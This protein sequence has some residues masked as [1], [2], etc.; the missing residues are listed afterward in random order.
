MQPVYVD[1][2]A[3][4]ITRVL[5]VTEPRAVYELGGSKTYTY[6]ALLMTIAR[7]T[8][9]NPIF[10]PVP[11]GMW[12]CLAYVAE[13][14]PR[15]PITRNQVELMQIDNVVTPGFPGF[16]DLQVSPHPIEAV[17]S[18]MCEEKL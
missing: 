11:F 18:R 8:H 4:A 1:D 15:P 14:L 2:V 13:M 16:A 3:E 7:R 5:Q 6:R 9:R 10:L 17:L 12:R